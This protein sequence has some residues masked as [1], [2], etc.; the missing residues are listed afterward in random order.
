MIWYASCVQRGRGGKGIFLRRR[1]LFYASV[2]VWENAAGEEE[3]EGKGGENHAFLFRMRRS[4]GR[5]L[6]FFK[7]L[8]PS[9]PPPPPLK[10]RRRRSAAVWHWSRVGKGIMVYMF[11]AEALRGQMTRTYAGGGANTHTH[12]LNGVGKPP[13]FNIPKKISFLHR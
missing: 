2:C 8:G 12:V 3:E 5:A 1:H 6:F 4:E 7:D 13:H 10:K 9:L 11:A